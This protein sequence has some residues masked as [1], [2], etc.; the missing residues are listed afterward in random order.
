MGDGM[1]V[2]T[3][4]GLLML[5]ATVSACAYSTGP[6]ERTD[7]SVG[8]AA[9]A[10]TTDALDQM[11]ARY[12]GASSYED[13][14]T[15]VEVY[16]PDDG[17]AEHTRRIE[18][19]TAFDRATGSFRFE[20]AG[21]KEYSDRH[22]IWRNGSGR[23]HRWWAIAPQVQDDD[24][25]DGLA[26]MA[27]VSRTTSRTVPSMLLGSAAGTKRDLG[28]AADGEDVAAGVPCVKLSAHRDENVSTLWISKADHSLRRVTSRSHLG[29]SAPTD[30]EL[31]R[32]VKGV[33]EDRRAEV[34]EVMRKPHPFVVESTT[35]YAPVFDRPVDA[36]RFDFS[37]PAAT[38][39]PP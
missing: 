10:A 16:R 33:P 18:F 29:G 9:T 3:A 17:S 36:K 27:G 15:V 8:A 2:A 14:G 35:D 7:P 4:F 32:L 20:Y 22:V 30:A 26:A 37:P 31:A 19:E 6:T 39:S 24:L 38:D 12:V 28:Y 21:E 5:G 34:I 25:D 11:Y 13:H 23:A 1:R